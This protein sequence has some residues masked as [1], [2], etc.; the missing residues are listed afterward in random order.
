MV[1]SGRFGDRL[2]GRDDRGRVDLEAD[3]DEGQRDD[4][5]AG[6]LRRL[7]DVVMV[8]RIERRGVDVLGDQLRRHRG[9]VHVHPDDLAR[10]GAGF[11]RDLGKIE[12]VAVARRDA[13]LLAFQPLEVG[14]AGALEHEQRVRRLAIERR[15][16]LDRH[17]L[18]RPGGQTEATS[19][20]PKSNAPPASLVSVSP[21][22]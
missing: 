1:R 2:V 3:L 21:E 4:L 9:G 19:A 13:D 6:R 15:D 10:I 16:G 11:F 5:L 20:T 17:V 8:D 12:F 22:P 14:D 18:A 7:V